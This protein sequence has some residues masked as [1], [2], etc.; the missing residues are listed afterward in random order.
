M[1]K[2]DYSSWALGSWKK[3][4]KVTSGRFMYN[5]DTDCCHV[6]IDIGNGEETIIVDDDYPE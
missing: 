4:G 2:N 3:K 1:T 6:R 5:Q